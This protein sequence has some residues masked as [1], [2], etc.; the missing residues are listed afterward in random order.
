MSSRLWL[1]VAAMAAMTFVVKGV[2]PAILGGRQA[3]PWFNRVVVL[4][5]PAVLTALVVTQAFANGEELAVGADTVGVGA[6][7]IVFWRRG[8]V[9]VGVAVAMAVTASLRAMH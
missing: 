1:L 7:G 3:P 9:L 4:L 5:G 8:S 6:A 2:G